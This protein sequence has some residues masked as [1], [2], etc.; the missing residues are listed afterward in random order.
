MPVAGPVSIE[1]LCQHTLDNLSQLLTA[2]RGHGHGQ[3]SSH[4]ERLQVNTLLENAQVLRLWSSL[5]RE[6]ANYIR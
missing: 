5:V 4:G 3:L 1:R 6:I 2:P